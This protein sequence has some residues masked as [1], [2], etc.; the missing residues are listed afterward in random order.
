[1]NRLHT[2]LLTSLTIAFLALP[3]QAQR[4]ISAKHLVRP[5]ETL[6]LIAQFYGVDIYT[7]AI[8]N[9]ISNAH[10][11]HAWQ[12]LAI[13]GLAAPETSTRAASGTHI[14]R[15]GETLEI[16]AI[17]YGIDLSELQ[18]LNNIYTAWI[19]PGDELLLPVPGRAPAPEPAYETG[20][21]SESPI[22]TTSEFTHT[23]LNGESLGAIAEAYGVNLYDLQTLNNIWGW[24]IYP[25]QELI[26]P[27]GGTPPPAVVEPI[28]PAPSA[29]SP[30]PEA[31]PDT[32][33]VQRG[34]TLGTIA[35]SYG[36]DLYDLQTLNNI[37][38]WLIYPGQ[39]L[40]IPA[41]GTPPPAI[42]EPITPAPSLPSPAPEALPD[43]HV[44]QGGETLFS[45]AL[46]YGVAVD[47]LARANGIADPT[48]IHSGLT[49]RV[50][51]LDTFIPPT[52]E[53]SAAP[54]APSA[55]TTPAAA[56][57]EQYVVRPGDYLSLIGAKFNMS[58]LAI[59][60]VNG[61]T[62]PDNVKVGT[63]LQI[64]T[65]EEAAKYG[66]A[67]GNFF[68]TVNH[69]GAHIGVGREFVVVLSAQM[70]Y[71]YEDGVL[72]YSA[73]VSSGLP[74][75]PTVQGDFKIK[76]KVRSQSMSGIDYDLDNVEWVMYFYAGYAFHGTWW[77][78]NFGTPMSRG[79]VNMTNA[80]A[81][82][83]Y[84]FG[85]IGTPVHVQYY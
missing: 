69:P 46:R 36:V 83:F 77:H 33:V 62:D 55:P 73:L 41:G 40:I 37:W 29:P 65:A 49:L 15:P 35:A 3:V 75:T 82:W 79:C 32:H 2:L 22:A 19:Y 28:T 52:R 64:P 53:T 13:P 81:K 78:Y 16:I 12:E 50:T 7:L 60:E 63:V 10:F 4:G 6:G 57:R 61:I 5:G 44:V 11:I 76:R 71:A 54:A 21:L 48:R 34:E 66:P 43:T 56:N 59:V 84:D 9:G 25:G 68:A 51:N 18:A 47:A 74:D 45:I 38:S 17:A 85:E 80:D 1:M 8:N 58:W 20:T 14:V 27:E 26:I 70:A 30:A 23:V 24:L 72:Q 67:Y 31:Q 42:I 39:E